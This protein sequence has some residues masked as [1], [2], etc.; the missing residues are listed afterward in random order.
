M[1]YRASKALSL[2]ASKHRVSINWVGS[3]FFDHDFVQARDVFVDDK[4]M[5]WDG[6]LTSK[7]QTPSSLS[8]LSPYIIFN[9]QVEHSQIFNV[10]IH[11]V[12]QLQTRLTKFNIFCTSHQYWCVPYSNELVLWKPANQLYTNHSILIYDK[13]QHTFLLDQIIKKQTLQIERWH[14]T[15]IDVRMVNL[16]NHYPFFIQSDNPDTSHLLIPTWS[17]KT[18]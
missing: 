5:S 8:S 7:F 12:L 2:I 13:H 18:T 9:Q 1:L 15:D 16:F 6:S 17:V 3:S 11:Q 4:I 10:P 14:T